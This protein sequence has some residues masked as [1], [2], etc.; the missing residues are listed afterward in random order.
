L[1]SDPIPAAGSGPPPPESPQ[2]NL[3]IFTKP[4]DPPATA[5][6]KAALRLLAGFHLVLNLTRE[7]G[8]QEVWENYQNR[9]GRTFGLL[10]R[11]IQAGS[12]FSQEYRDLVDKYVLKLSRDSLKGSCGT[13]VQEVETGS[14]DLYKAPRFQADYHLF[15]GQ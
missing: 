4:D 11:A 14:W 9:N 7:C 10:Y 6:F 8:K 15:I 5:R 3:S 13:F 1:A 2:S 12:G